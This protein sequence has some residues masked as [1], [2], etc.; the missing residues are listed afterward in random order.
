MDRDADP[1][2]CQ[3]A[4]DVVQKDP[5]TTWFDYTAQT[6]EAQ[7]AEALT[8]GVEQVKALNHSGF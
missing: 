2:V 8:F 4:D 6:R 7:M 3:A 5:N 1:P